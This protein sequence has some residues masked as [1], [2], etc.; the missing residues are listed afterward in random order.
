VIKM[1]VRG[2]I[3]QHSAQA[4]T[5]HLQ[6]GLTWQQ[7]ARKIG[8]KHL[9]GTIEPYFTTVHLERAIAATRVAEERAERA[10][11]KRPNSSIGDE[12]AS[13]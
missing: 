10:R 3:D 13:Q 6:N 4:A 11:S 7:L 12:L 9:N 1:M 2:E 5:W 8:A